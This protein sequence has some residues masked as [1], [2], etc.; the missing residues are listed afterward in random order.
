MSNHRLNVLIC[1]VFV[2]IFFRHFI[3]TLFHS[4]H[5][6]FLPLHF[7][8]LVVLTCVLVSYHFLSLIDFR[9]LPFSLSR[10]AVCLL[11]VFLNE[12]FKP[13]LM[14]GPAAAASLLPP[15][16]ANQRTKRFTMRCAVSAK[17]EAVAVM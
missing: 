10:V 3:Y 4:L 2:L 1:F 5:D 12:Y 17:E 6:L 13:L 14:L 15:S 9:H 11:Y 16:V 7:C 8:S